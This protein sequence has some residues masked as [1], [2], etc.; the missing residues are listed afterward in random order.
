[1]DFDFGYRECNRSPRCDRFT[2]VFGVAIIQL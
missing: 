2:E 1:M